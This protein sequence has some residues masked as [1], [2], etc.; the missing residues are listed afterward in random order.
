MKIFYE[1]FHI[2]SIYFEVCDYP[3]ASYSNTT[4]YSNE[5]AKLEDINQSYKNKY[6]G[7]FFRSPRFAPIF[8]PVCSQPTLQSSSIY[9][10]FFEGRLSIF[11]FFQVGGELFRAL[12]HR[13][14]PRRK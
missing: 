6:I 12:S 11:F 9:L 5:C 14:D 13:S 10:F 7:S 2:L 3:A 1:T 4:N 8:V